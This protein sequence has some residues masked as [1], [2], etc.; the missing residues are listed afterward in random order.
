VSAL[1][2]II[3]RE[4]YKDTAALARLLCSA[5]NTRD[6]YGIVVS[7]LIEWF[8]DGENGDLEIED[9]RAIMMGA[10]L[11][12]DDYQL[13]P[14]ARELFNADVPSQIEERASATRTAPGDGSQHDT[15]KLDEAKEIIRGLLPAALSGVLG[16]VGGDDADAFD[17]D[18]SARAAYNDPRLSRARSFLKENGE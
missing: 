6:A 13:R 7:H 18:A 15:N 14:M 1:Q 10:D 8:A 11:M 12:D 2:S 4:A 3:D 17:M 5:L 9:Y 16:E